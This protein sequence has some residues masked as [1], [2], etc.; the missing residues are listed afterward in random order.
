MTPLLNLVI[1]LVEEHHAGMAAGFISTM[2][3]VGGAFGV[4]VVGMFFSSLLGTRASGSQPVAARYAEAFAGAMLYNL[5]AVLLAA[6]LVAWVVCGWRVSRA[7]R[8]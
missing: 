8:L 5:V 7:K 1:G 6:L 4:A 2:Q 3:Q